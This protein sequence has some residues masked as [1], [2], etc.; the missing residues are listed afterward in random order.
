MKLEIMDD[1]RK[2]QQMADDYF[3]QSI[4]DIHY[5]PRT[6]EYYFECPA[7]SLMS[8][9]E[10]KI[11]K[12]GIQRYEAKTVPALE[13]KMYDLVKYNKAFSLNIEDHYS[14]GI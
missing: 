6:L 7:L 13:R 1:I 2:L 10:E 8:Q 11:D 4:L 12:I 9:P 3:G 14:L 5:N